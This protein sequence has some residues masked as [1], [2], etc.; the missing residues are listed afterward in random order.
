MQYIRT[1]NQNDNIYLIKGLGKTIIQS[2][3]EK[4]AIKISFLMELGN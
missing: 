1:Y 2:E 4:K 3:K